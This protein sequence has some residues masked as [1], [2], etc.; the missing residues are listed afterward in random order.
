MGSVLIIMLSGILSLFLV[1]AGIAGFAGSYQ[2]FS[3]QSLMLGSSGY[4]EYSPTLAEFM[5]RD[6][7][8]AR[9]SPT[10]LG[11][12]RQCVPV[13]IGRPVPDFADIAGA[14]WYPVWP[15]NGSPSDRARFIPA[16]DPLNIEEYHVPSIMEFLEPDYQ[17]EGINYTNYVPSLG[18]FAD[19]RWRPP[20]A[21][22]SLYTPS[23][24]EFLDAGWLPIGPG[25][26][27]YPMRMAGSAW[28]IFGIFGQ[29]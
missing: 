23:I 9:P 6:S 24:G 19:S 11:R 8:S 27:E 5:A 17:S 29:T 26:S 15:Y 25:P 3:G 16:S 21:N 20:H 28:V 2:M 7:I 1:V 12:D 22:Y 14:R 4:P 13:Q 18:E 10:Y